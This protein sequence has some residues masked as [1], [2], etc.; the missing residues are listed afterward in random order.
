METWSVVLTLKVT[1]IQVVLI[2]TEAMKQLNKYPNHFQVLFAFKQEKYLVWKFLVLLAKYVKL[3]K[4]WL[5]NLLS[6]RHGMCKYPFYHFLK[7]SWQLPRLANPQKAKL[8][9]YETLNLALGKWWEMG[10][11]SW[12][13]PNFLQKGLPVGIMG[14]WKSHITSKLQLSKHHN[15]QFYN[16]GFVISMFCWW[17]SWNQ[18]VCRS[19]G[20]SKLR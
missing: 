2:W 14:N 5:N 4:P 20:S 10:K 7:N 1:L 11:K 3:I 9:I 19:G 6:K 15:L 13:V 16:L 18:R 8:K 12:D 17:P